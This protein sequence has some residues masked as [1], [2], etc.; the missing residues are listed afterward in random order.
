VAAEDIELSLLVDGCF[1]AYNNDSC[2][3]SREE[4]RCREERCDDAST[5][6]PAVIINVDLAAVPP[7]VSLED[8]DDFESFAIRARVPEHGFVAIDELK[9][10]A[11][12]RAGD[13]VWM[14]SL[15]RMLEYASAH[16]W[17]RDD[18]AVRAHVEVR[19]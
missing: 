19:D 2:Q 16:G 1:Y 3:R 5:E 10:L 11:G 15:D 13:P 4:S 9:R 12:D 7:A 18:G 17:L 8:P 6:E 14:E